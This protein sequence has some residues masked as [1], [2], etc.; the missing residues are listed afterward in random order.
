MHEKF[1]LL[2]LNLHALKVFKKQDICMENFHALLLFVVS[3]I[4]TSKFYTTYI[5]NACI[6]MYGSYTVV[7]IG[8]HLQ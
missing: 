6:C 1:L 7:I 2:L 5:A 8:Y 3:K 4:H